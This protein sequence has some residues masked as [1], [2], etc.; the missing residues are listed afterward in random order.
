MDFFCNMFFEYVRIFVISAQK[1][2]ADFW[3]PYRAVAYLCNSIRLTQIAQ[4]HASNAYMNVL[5]H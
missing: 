5:T 2:P 4:N 1:R 3:G